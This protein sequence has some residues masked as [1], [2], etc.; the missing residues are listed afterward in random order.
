MKIEKRIQ[1]AI[2]YNV[3]EIIINKDRYEN[4][5]QETKSLLKMSEVKITFKEEQK[6][7]MCKFE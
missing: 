2:G 7:F 6:D 1:Q 4:L 5:D 3:K